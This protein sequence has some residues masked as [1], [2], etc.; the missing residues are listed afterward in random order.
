MV[1]SGEQW[2]PPGAREPASAQLL[3]TSTAGTCWRLCLLLSLSFTL[4]LPDQTLD[5]AFMSKGTKGGPKRPSQPSLS[6]T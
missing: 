3:V 1:T 4:P 5:A 2:S 6:L